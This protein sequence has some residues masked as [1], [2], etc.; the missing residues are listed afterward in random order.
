[1]ADSRAD[2]IL[3]RHARLKSERSVLDSHCEE[4]AER[5]WPERAQ[6]LSQD[7]VPGQKMTEKMFDATAALALTRFAAA[8]ESMLTPRTQRWHRLRVPDE[9]L[10]ES[11]VIQRYLDDVTNILF[12]IRYSPRANYASQMHEGYMSLGAFGTGGMMVDEML[13]QGIRYKSCALSQLWFAEDRH[14]MVDTVH[15]EF[16]YTAR[17]AV[18][19]FGNK[20]PEKIQQK[21][22]KSPDDE[23]DFVHVVMPNSEAN[24]SDRTWRGMKFASYYISIEGRQV[25]EEG[26]YRTMPYPVGR[27]ITTPGE[28]YGRSPAMLVLPDIKMLNEMN[29]TIIRAAHLATSPPLLLQED[30]AL[31]AFDLR[32]NALNP[33]RLDSNGNPLVAPL[34]ITGRHEPGMELLEAKQR[35]IND[36]F[37]ITLFQILVD[38][39][40]ITATEAMLRAQEKGALLAPTMGRQQSEWLGA[41][42]I[43]EI[44]I[45]AHAGLLPEMPQEMLE[46]GGQIEIE[47]VSP[48]NRAQRAEDGVAIMRSLEAVAPIAQVDPKV[49]LVFNLPETAREIAEINGMPAKLLRTPEEIE[50][51]EEEIG[52]QADMAQLLEAAPVAAQTAKT[53]AE[54]QQLASQGAPAVH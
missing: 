39:P 10:N 52:A 35:T 4:I 49:M 9:S 21:A 45:A 38:Q 20:V 32:P 16:K 13:G 31:Q 2:E 47:Y 26:G 29:K 5:I 11:P 3:K 42:I 54:T 24:R 50:E 17:Q 37:L 25:V 36:A 14:G 30:G 34:Q 19:H 22:E 33:G 44:D 51:M 27:Y 48:L 43:R 12:R 1:V 28:T 46:I 41:Q 18:Q 23:F 6:F 7:K 53:L 8:M 15:R 40:Q